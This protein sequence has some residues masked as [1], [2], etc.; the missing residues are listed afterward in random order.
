G[1]LV[2]S[3]RLRLWRGRR[4]GGNSENSEGLQGG[5]VALLVLAAAL[6]I[7]AADLSGMSKAETE[8]IWLPFA[9]W[10]P[11]AGALL[12]RPRGWLAAQ[13]VLALLLNHLLLTGW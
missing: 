4:C 7:L 1:R 3:R 10:L 13:T 5:W 2:A 11:A 12:T 8:R 6:A 9:V